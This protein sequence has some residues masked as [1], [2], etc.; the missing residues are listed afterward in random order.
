MPR[1]SLRGEHFDVTMALSA[2]ARFRLDVVFSLAKAVKPI[3]GDKER[4]LRLMLGMAGLVHGTLLRFT[5]SI[6]LLDL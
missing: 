5:F 4:N 6:V 2:T 1:D 3:I